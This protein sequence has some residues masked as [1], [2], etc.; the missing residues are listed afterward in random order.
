MTR[1]M[2][3]TFF[4]DKRWAEGVHPHESPKVMTVPLIVL[5]ALSVFGGVMLIGDWIVDFLEPVTGTVPD[6]SPPIP[7]LA[8][9]AIVRR[10]RGRR[11]GR[12]VVLVGQ[13]DVPREAPQDVSWPVRAARA[14]LYGNEI[15]DELVVTSGRAARARA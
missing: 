8:I 9:S 12:G 1:L 13:R 3:M 15:N 6:E 5:A 2:L 11:R 7:A 4:T 14:E 10:D